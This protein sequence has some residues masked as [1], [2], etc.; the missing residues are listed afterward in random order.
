[1]P[2]TTKDEFRTLLCEP[3]ERRRKQKNQISIIKQF[4]EDPLRFILQPELT[5]DPGKKIEERKREL[6][7]RRDVLRTL[8][9]VMENELKL[10]SRALVSS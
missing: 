8:V 5:A 3:K 9:E 2:K 7:Y 4:C 1:M 6:E 10:L